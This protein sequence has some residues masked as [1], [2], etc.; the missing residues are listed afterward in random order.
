[1]EE[2]ECQYHGM[3]LTPTELEIEYVE[4]APFVPPYQWLKIEKEGEGTLAPRW[5]CV[6][7]VPWLNL[8]KKSGT[9][10]D[11][12]RVNVQHKI[13]KDM[14]VGK[15][16]G[17]IT[18]NSDS[19]PN[20]PITVTVTLNI[21]QK[22]EPVPPLKITTTSLPDGVQ[23]QPYQCLLEAEGGKPPYN[24][25]ERGLPTDLAINAK[26]GEVRGVP[27]VKGTNAILIRVQDTDGAIASQGYTLDIAEQPLTLTITSPIGGEVW[28]IG[29]TYEI[30]WQTNDGHD[31]TVDILLL[32]DQATYT[33]ATSVPATSLKYSWTISEGASDNNVITLV[34][35]T[36]TSQS[37]N[38][39]IREGGGCLIPWPVNKIFDSLV[40]KRIS[41]RFDKP[42]TR[43]YRSGSRS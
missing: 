26:T 41:R 15:Y 8:N 16:E 25:I 39:A 3:K 30:T 18:F 27:Y 11:S 2:F 9:V 14:A 7:D 12:I 42:G 10:P 19:A 1:M 21:I 35:S 40:R 36:A 28:F 17:H 20:T 43:R 32:S 4:N 34:S 38:F 23:G 6:T 37:G 29:D 33:I 24:W 22:P 13:V 5:H 31:A